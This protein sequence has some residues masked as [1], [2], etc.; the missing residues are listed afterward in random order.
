MGG[1]IFNEKLLREK[2]IIEMDISK[3]NNKVP[4]TV[5]WEYPKGQK[6][7]AEKNHIYWQDLAF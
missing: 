6:E 7:R 5:F 1:G 4:F 3:N 2:K